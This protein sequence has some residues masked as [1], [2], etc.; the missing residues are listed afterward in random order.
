MGFGRCLSLLAAG[1]LNEAWDLADQEYQVAAAQE[2]MAPLGGWAGF[3]GAVRLGEVRLVH[4]R[5]SELAT[6]ICCDATNA[7][8]DAG[9]RLHEVGDHQPGRARTAAQ[10]FLS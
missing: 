10:S 3:H 6:E 8:A 7:L 4:I 9:T 2:A 5:L 1:R